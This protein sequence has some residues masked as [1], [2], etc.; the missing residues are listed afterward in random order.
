MPPILA[1]SQKTYM[2]IFGQGGVF[3]SFPQKTSQNFGRKGLGCKKC[4]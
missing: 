3:L 4:I 2:G 1:S